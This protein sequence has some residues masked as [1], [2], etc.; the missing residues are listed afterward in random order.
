MII[1]ILWLLYISLISLAYYEVQIMKLVQK[2]D[3]VIWSPKILFINSFQPYLSPFI[4]VKVCSWN[5][6]NFNKIETF[7][8][9]PGYSILNHRVLI[10]CQYIY[11]SKT[12]SSA[13]LGMRRQKRHLERPLQWLSCSGH[14]G[15]ET[16][17]STT[18]SFTETLIVCFILI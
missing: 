18:F 15:L 14:T 2:W 13:H 16:D 4:H 11:S 5:D 1:I 3:E 8:Y 9:E 6:W 12:N 7:Y 10:I 17:Q